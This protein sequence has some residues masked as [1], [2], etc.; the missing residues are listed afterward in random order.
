MA[1]KS[2][3]GQTQ[4]SRPKT[5]TRSPGSTPAFSRPKRAIRM[6]SRS[7]FQSGTDS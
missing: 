5:A 2:T 3:T 6:A 4:L 1:A 7:S